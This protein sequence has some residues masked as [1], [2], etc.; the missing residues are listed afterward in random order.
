M[1][2]SGPKLTLADTQGRLNMASGKKKWIKGSIKHPGSFREAAE[3][4]GKTTREFAKEHEHD[5]GKL[6]DRAR[7]AETL[8]GMSRKAKASRRYTH[9]S[10][11]K[12]EG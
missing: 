3:R 12:A 7:L 8:M 9:G 4:A 1:I 10:N 11:A 6:G 2:P 5:S